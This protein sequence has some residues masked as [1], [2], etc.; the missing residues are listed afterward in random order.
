M[1]SLCAAVQEIVAPR[2]SVCLLSVLDVQLTV[3]S[4]EG[5]HGEG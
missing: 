4:A 1:F 5:V 2:N 3:R